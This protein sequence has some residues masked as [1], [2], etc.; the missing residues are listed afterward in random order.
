[1]KKT[2]A[3]F[4]G[5]YLPHL[6]GVER[7]T[8]NIAKKLIAKDYNVII[9]TT[10]HEESLLN[11]EIIEG[12]KIYRL[13]I[14]NI[15][16]ERYPF[17]KKNSQFKELVNKIRT[18]KIDYFVANTRFHLPALLG[19]KLAKEQGKKAIVIEHGSSYLTLN[20]FVL[21]F[22]LRFVERRLIANVKKNTDLFYGVSKEAAAWLV[23]FDINAKG[24]LSNAI[25]TS[26][27]DRYYRKSEK[28]DKIVISYS[29]RL[30]PK[31]KGVEMLLATFEKLSQQFDDLELIIAGDGPL[32]GQMVKKYT[33]DNIKF[34]G[35]INHD[36]VMAL[37][38]KSDVFVLM[39]RSEGFST[40]MLEA[41]L[42]ENVVITTE[43]VGGA[44]DMIADESYG[45]IIDNNEE[46]L[47]NTLKSILANKE[48][49]GKI[50]TNVSKRVR[51][52]FTWDITTEKF[53][54]VFE[55][56]G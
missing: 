6:G 50:K 27:F 46:S 43:T 48:K 2:V 11:E 9:V 32:L 56:I 40:A 37:N 54:E 10:Q 16:K 51:E 25:E 38:A 23:E 14:K 53:I 26:E 49:I 30:Q 20:N 15:W 34:L 28:N 13:P 29:G 52:Q 31:I 12:I 8:H 7:Y 42:L 22:G 44:R 41:A 5:Y 24:V 17:L 35:F 47:F 1:M 19:I 36:E 33:Q 4:N 39:S 45:F 18:E 3:F 21:N 55:E